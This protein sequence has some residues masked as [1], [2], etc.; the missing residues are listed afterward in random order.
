VGCALTPLSNGTCA[1]ILAKPPKVNPHCLCPDA[2]WSHH[3][4]QNR[5]RQW[6]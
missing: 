2:L 1:R 5:P 6:R 3:L 4:T